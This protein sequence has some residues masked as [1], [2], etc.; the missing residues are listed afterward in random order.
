MANQ[1]LP[2]I[3][4]DPTID[5]RFTEVFGKNAGAVKSAFLTI[6]NGN[7]LLQKCSPRSIL[8]AVG[9]A[10]VLN[11]SITP[12]MGQAY[13]VPYRGEAQFHYEGELTGFNPFTGEPERAKKIFSDTVV[14]YGAYLVF[15]VDNQL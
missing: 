6:W 4:K 5:N 15:A 10:G 1:N 3:L 8:G 11:L 2:T 12:S 9:F 7:Q 13:I 14:G